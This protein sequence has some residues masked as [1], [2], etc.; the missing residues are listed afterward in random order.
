MLSR[1][2]R[3]WPVALFLFVFTAF[4]ARAE[5]PFTLKF[6][7][8]QKAW[9][10]IAARFSGTPTVTKNRGTIEVA[11]KGLKG[12]KPSETATASIRVD[13]ASGHVIEVGS[14][15]AAFTDDEFA[16]FAQFPELRGLTLWHNHGAGFNGTG[17]AH[18]AALP[19]LERVTLAGGSLNDAGMAELAKIKTLREFHA[20]HAAYTDAG[21]AALRQHPALESFRVGPQW[22]PNFTDPA[23][24]AL[25]TCPK[26][27]RVGVD[28][29]WLTWDGSLHLLADR[30]DTLKSIDLGACLLDPADVDRLR[31]ALPK[32]TIQW[33][34]LPAAGTALQKPQVRASAEK[35]MPK[36]L[37][38]RAV[39]EAEKGVAGKQ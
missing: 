7:G 17:L 13:E 12:P 19:K 26:L 25:A 5:D 4:A 33:K 24:A 2:F 3:P 1:L 16:T 22:K 18:L 9:E 36:E 23:L 38:A 27:T 29:T 8:E 28:E 14:N 34:G 6:P 31:A 35:W 21:V 39:A 32:A 15:G 20:W 10:T 37:I 11:V 30:R